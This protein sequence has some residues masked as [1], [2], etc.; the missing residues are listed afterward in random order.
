MVSMSGDAMLSLWQGMDM[1]E[2]APAGCMQ[3]DLGDS[4]P[5]PS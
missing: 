1:L 5:T 4:A 3:V 2:A